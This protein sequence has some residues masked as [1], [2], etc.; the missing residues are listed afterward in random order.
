MQQVIYRNSI[1]SDRELPNWVRAVDKYTE[2]T[3]LI[4]RTLQDSQGNDYGTMTEAIA[5]IL[6]GYDY[7]DLNAKDIINQKAIRT[8]LKAVGIL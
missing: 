4:Q 8:E 6:P 1:Y 5:S 7:T 3:N 2:G